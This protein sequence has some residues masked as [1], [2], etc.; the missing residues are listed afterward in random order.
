MR[1]EAAKKAAKEAIENTLLQNIKNLM[2]T[3][4]LSAEQAM[5]ALKISDSDRIRYIEKL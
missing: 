3:M 4:K 5:D 1:D 2:E